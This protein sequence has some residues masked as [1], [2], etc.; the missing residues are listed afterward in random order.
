MVIQV[1]LII[2][3]FTF[4][5]IIFRS[6]TLTAVLS[7][8]LFPGF[9]YV[10]RSLWT[11]R[12]ILYFPIFSQ[13]GQEQWFLFPDWLS[14]D[15]TNINKL[16][17]PREWDLNYTKCSHFCRIQC[18]SRTI[19]QCAQ[20]PWCSKPQ[21][22]QRTSSGKS[23]RPNLLP[24]SPNNCQQLCDWPQLC[25][26]M[27][28]KRVWIIILCS[29]IEGIEDFWLKSIRPLAQFEALGPWLIYFMCKYDTR[30][31]LCILF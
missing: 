2:R 29:W 24:D 31:F 8:D 25:V 7:R 6:N 27:C 19:T 28:R 4:A 10:H 12:G 22:A 11:F 13:T 3:L 5:D 30:Y 1:L 26:I 23:H 16:S 14:T 15:I 9:Q 18:S 17:Y 20:P 21:W